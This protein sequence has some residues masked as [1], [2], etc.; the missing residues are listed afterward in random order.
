MHPIEILQIHSRSELRDFVRFAIDLYKG[1]D[2]YV[3]PIIKTEVDSLTAE[4]NPAFDFC[5]AA[6]FMA[7]CDGKAVGRIAGFINR[8]FNEKFNRAQCRFCYVDFV[9]DQAVS[10][11]LLDVVRT[12]GKKKGC[13][14]LVGPLGLTDL[15]YEGCLT[16]GFDQLGTIS[17]IYNYPYYSR[18]FEAYGLQKDAEWYEYRMRI[19]EAIPEKHQLV[20]RIVKERLGLR[21]VKDTNAKTF[22]PRY[23]DKIFRLLN[24]AYA[25]LYGFCELTERQIKYYIDLYL[26]QIRLSLVRVIVDAED[27]VV[28]FGVTCP[29][30]SRAQQKAKGSLFPWGWFHMAKAMYMKG[31]TDTWDLYLIA[32]RPDLQGKGVN[33]L[34]FTE[35]IPEAHRNGFV[36]CES[37]P[38]LA[39]NT[40]VQSQ[41]QYFER[42]QHKRRCS[43]RMDI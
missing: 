12:W 2:C 34:L 39:S 36:W 35:L 25:P 15:D 18:H 3:P 17:T 24:E 7:Y 6:Y 38:E 26:P 37:N 42:M 19:P 33:A 11:A 41:W 13:T 40:K 29:S 16:F 20:A 23:G 21:V 14:E 4:I 31:G 9:D 5:D 30:L 8:R 32:V 28:A 22:I 1:N 10:K 27:N 43:F